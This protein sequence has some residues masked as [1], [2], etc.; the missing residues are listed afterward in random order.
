M[1][2][3]SEA[4]ALSFI[5]KHL[6]DESS[7]LPKVTTTNPWIASETISNFSIFGS[8]DQTGFDF[9]EFE[10]KP[11]ITDLVTHRFTDLVWLGTF[12]TA[13]EAARAYDQAA[14]RLRGSKA[15]VNFP[16]EVGTWNQRADVGQNKRKRDGEGEE[17]T[18]VAKVLKTEESHAVETE[19]SSLTAVDDWDLTELLSMPLLSPLS[20]HPPFGYP[21]LTVVPGLSLVGILR[22]SQMWVPTLSSSSCSS[23]ENTGEEA[24][25][26]PVYLNVYDLTPVNNYLYWFG[27]GIFH[28]GIESHGLEYCYGAH[29]YP[30]SGVYEVEPKNCPGFIF[31]RSVLLGTTTMSRSDFRSYM[32]KLSRKYHGDTYHLIAKN[33]N[34]FTEQVCLQLTGKPV[35]GWINRLAR[36]GSFC[37]CLL[38]ESIQLTAV[39][40]P[41]ERLEFS[42]EDE[43]NSEASSVSDDEGP[44][45]RLIN[46]ADREVVYLQNKPVRLTREEIH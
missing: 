30:T 34:H 28:S 4:S 14:F 23:D 40:A 1:A 19:T 10:T 16:L 31:R 46:V 17:V 3:P 36:V 13:I 15:I 33:C 7:P 43:S 29:E 24:R 8:F 18:V 42:D 27:I 45:H 41:S 2:T 25:L 44:E 6:L 22:L 37:N 32:E 35:P 9:S 5:K 11:E 12:D 20:P 38:P 26:T 21:Q 39:S